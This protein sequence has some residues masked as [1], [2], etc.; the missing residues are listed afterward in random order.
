[1][2]GER[3]VL[4]ILAKDGLHVV[5]IDGEVD[6]ANAAELEQQIAERTAEASA[7]I[8]DLSATSYLDSSGIRLLDHLVRAHERR[9]ARLVIV[10]PEGGAA[11]Y[12][13][14]LCAFRDDLVVRDTA[15]A[16]TAL[17][18]PGGERT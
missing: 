12:V 14:E 7:V 6:L 2:S 4:R 8:V 11:A 15:A 1:M 13:L 10:A 18:P 3:P 16:R 5:S 17:A 9:G